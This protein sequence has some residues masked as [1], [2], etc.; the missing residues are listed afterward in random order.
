MCNNNKCTAKLLLMNCTL[1]QIKTAFKYCKKG[2]VRVKTRHPG[3]KTS[4]K[5]TERWFIKYVYNGF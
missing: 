2:I 5:K 3:S 4:N 1:N